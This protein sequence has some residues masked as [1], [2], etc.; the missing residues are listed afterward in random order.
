LKA[1][2]LALGL[3]QEALSSMLGVAQQ[4]VSHWERDK[5]PPIGAARNN[6][7]GVL[8]VNWRALETGEGFRVPAALPAVTLAEEGTMAAEESGKKP[9]LLPKVAPGEGWLVEAESGKSSPL[10]PHGAMQEIEKALQEGG[11]VWLVVKRPKRR[12]R[13]KKDASAER[14]PSRMTKKKV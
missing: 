6:L 14:A 3:S 8:G 9:L 4:S 11:S 5:V 12:P 2:R 1:I 7:A 13:A 10:N